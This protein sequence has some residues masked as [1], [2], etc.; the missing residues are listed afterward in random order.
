M[1]SAAVWLPQAKRRRSSAPLEISQLTRDLVGLGLEVVG[2]YDARFGVTTVAGAVSQWDDARGPVGF[3]PGLVQATAG[4]RPTYGAAAG[5][6][7]FD[8]TA[9]Y[10]RDSTASAWDAI[11]DSCGIAAVGTMPDATATSANVAQLSDGA[12]DFPL[13][14]YL[15]ESAGTDRL[16]AQAGAAS[17]V[18]DN[19][20][21]VTDAL[22]RVMHARRTQVG[23]DATVGARIGSGAES[24]A[25]GS[26]AALV[27][28]RLT[29]GANRQDTASGFYG[30]VLR[31]VVIVAGSYTDAAQGAVNAWAVLNHGATL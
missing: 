14:A 18:A 13:G 26:K 12:T 9:D 25:T 19:V 2:F 7:T 21:Y 27:P 11:A 10:L 1:P 4:A 15:L 8:G 17:A 16:F 20:V 22:T 23:G 3:A 24:P 28:N 5:T 30:G 31:A 6:I 29:V